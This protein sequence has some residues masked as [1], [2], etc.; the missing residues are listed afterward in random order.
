MSKKS[1]LKFSEIT[2]FTISNIVKEDIN[3]LFLLELSRF[4]RFKII[5]NPTLALGTRVQNFIL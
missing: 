3:T 4:I 2:I 5:F 1:G